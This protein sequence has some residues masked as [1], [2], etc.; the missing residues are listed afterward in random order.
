MKAQVTYHAADYYMNVG[1]IINVDKKRDTVRLRFSNGKTEWFRKVDLGRIN[2]D[3]SI[4]L[5]P[6]EALVDKEDDV[7]FRFHIILEGRG[8]NKEAAFYRAIQEFYKSPGDAP[9][10][11]D[12]LDKVPTPEMDIEPGKEYSENITTVFREGRLG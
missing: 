5:G 8:K 6:W 1:E 4:T 3:G 11:I 12:T 2:G 9:P 7:C 10:D